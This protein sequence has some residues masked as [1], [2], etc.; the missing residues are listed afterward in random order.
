VRARF[1]VLAAIGLAAACESA[2][3]RV[4]VPD[5]PSEVTLI[6]GASTRDVAVGQPVVLHAER[7]SR[8]RWT[9]VDRATLADGQCWMAQPPPARELEVAD[10][11]HWRV[12]PQVP[13]RFN[14]AFRSDH[15]R[16]VTFSRAGTYT[17]EAST[18]VWCGA[19]A[20]ARAAPI[21]I[22]VRP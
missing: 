8:G 15:T 2:P 20:G 9:Q 19:A 13:A 3:T 10:N 5:G 4:Y 14:T 11:V 16:E 1:L 17:V 6:I 21:M 18:A 7:F 12:T 22:Q